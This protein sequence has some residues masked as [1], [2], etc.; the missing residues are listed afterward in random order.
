M[1][2]NKDIPLELDKNQLLFLILSRFLH[3][4]SMVTNN[5][6][7]V[8]NPMKNGFPQILDENRSLFL[9]SSQHGLQIVSDI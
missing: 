4:S 2:C 1:D 8:K 5:N 9:N 6:Q 3:I 7:N